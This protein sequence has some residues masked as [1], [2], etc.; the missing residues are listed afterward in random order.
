MAKMVWSFWIL[1]TLPIRR[2]LRKQVVAEGVPR[3]DLE[4][5]NGL[6]KDLLA[7]RTRI[8]VDDPE[9]IGSVL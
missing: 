1:L 4:I 5:N 6:S 7:W 8:H 3:N 9:K 2:C